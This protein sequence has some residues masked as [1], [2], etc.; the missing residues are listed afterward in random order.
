MSWISGRPGLSRR[1]TVT[2]AD[3][4]DQPGAPTAAM[5]WRRFAT[6]SSIVYWRRR[7][8]NGSGEPPIVV[9]HG[10][11]SDHAGLREVIAGLGD[12]DVVAP[13]L[14]GHGQSSPLTH[15]HTVVAYADAVE[16]LRTLLAADSI[17]LVGHSLG[18]N[19]ALT[20]AGLH[21]HRVNALGLLHPVSTATGLSARL[22]RAYYRIGSW[23]PQ[24][25]ARWWI[26]S[27]PAVRLGDRLTV[28]TADRSR[29]RAIIEQD[30]RT[31]VMASPR[32]IGEVY[33]SLLTTPFDYL[34]SRV[35]APTLIVTGSR[36]GFARPASVRALH[37]LI[38]GS[39][40]AVIHDAGHLW[41][42]EDPAAAAQ[43]VTSTLLSSA[44]DHMVS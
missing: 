30:Y 33:R 16:E 29:R 24:R 20:Y 41:P 5:P 22:G 25:L 32:A 14:P 18:A 43:L 10:L 36:D 11:A 37:D 2:S 17:I 12:R 1:R 26:L 23:L 34:A 38:P 44:P 39:T 4:M 35:V 15:A 19:I 21:P 28:T 42:V 40:L 27:R 6:R 3:A 31:A 8:S 9:L 13:D 7:S